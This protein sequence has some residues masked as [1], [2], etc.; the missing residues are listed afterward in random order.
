M[1]RNMSE[2]VSFISNRC[3]NAAGDYHHT[4][5]PQPT[6]IIKHDTKNYYLNFWF[7]EFSILDLSN[8]DFH[9]FEF[10]RSAKSADALLVEF[11]IDFATDYATTVQK[12]A[13]SYGTQPKLP[14]WVTK[15]TIIGV[16]GSH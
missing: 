15:G 3:C 1:G 13:L 7:N 11:D 12:L 2:I 4:Y 14:R 16:C 9:E 8:D 6:I 10:H 5:W